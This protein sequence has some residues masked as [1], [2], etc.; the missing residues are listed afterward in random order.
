M[1]YTSE[2]LHIFFKNIW[3][4]E[5]TMCEVSPQIG[6]GYHMVKMQLSVPK[7]FA[8]FNH[9]GFLSFTLYKF[10]SVTSVT[11]AFSLFKKN[12]HNT[13]RHKRYC[14][15]ISCCY[16]QQTEVKNACFCFYCKCLLN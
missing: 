12:P 8:N 16:Q 15:D 1:T 14:F 11:L 3:C 9:K 4:F 10:R 7:L 13:N 6:F 5:E 2:S